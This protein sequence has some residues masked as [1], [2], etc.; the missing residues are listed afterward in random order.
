MNNIF[1]YLQYIIIEQFVI[2]C[3]AKLH[4]GK[5]FN[6]RILPLLQRNLSWDIFQR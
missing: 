2:T 6:V 1:D 4:V 3:G 5:F